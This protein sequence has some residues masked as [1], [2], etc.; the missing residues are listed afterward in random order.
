MNESSCWKM[1]VEKHSAVKSYS[2]CTA[3][4][5]AIVVYE[6]TFSSVTFAM[7]YFIYPSAHVAIDKLLLSYTAFI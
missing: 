5:L 6:M 3:L 1:D 4:S 7:F 2:L